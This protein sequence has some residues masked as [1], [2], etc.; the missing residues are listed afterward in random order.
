[1]STFPEF[2]EREEQYGSLIKGMKYEKEQ[3]IKK[4][5]YILDRPKDNLNNLDMV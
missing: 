1:M 5:N 4:E 2:K 3:R